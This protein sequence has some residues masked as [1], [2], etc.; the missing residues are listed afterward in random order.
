MYTPM[1]YWN[2]QG[3]TQAHAGPGWISFFTGSIN[4]TFNSLPFSASVNAGYPTF[5]IINFCQDVNTETQFYK[6]ITTDGQSSPLQWPVG[7]PFFCS[8][9]SP[10][11][12]ININT[13][14]DTGT[15]AWYID[16]SAD[17]G[18]YNSYSPTQY[19]S[20][21]NQ[22]GIIVNETLPFGE[23]KRIISQNACFF[24]KE[25]QTFPAG[26]YYG[27][28]L[29]WNIVSK[30]PGSVTPYV[31]Q[32]NPA[33]YEFTI[34]TSS[35]I[36]NPQGAFNVTYNAYGYASGSNYAFWQTGGNFGTVGTK[37]TFSGSVGL[38]LNIGNGFSNY[39]NT[40]ITNVT[41]TA[42]GALYL[43][44]CTT[45]HSLWVTLNN[46]VDV[47][48]TG[49]ILK[50]TNTELTTTS[51]CW[52]LSNFTSSLSVPVTV[53]N[54]IVSNTFNTCYTC[55]SGSLTASLNVDYLLVAGGGGGGAGEALGGPGGAGGGAGGLLSGS[56]T[57][58]PLSV[59]SVVIGTGGRGGSTNAQTGSNGLNSSIFGYTTI[60]G[61]YGGV[62]FK[63]GSN[64]GSGGGSGG[65]ASAL[66]GLGTSGQGN[67]GGSGSAENGGGAGGG[68]GASSVGTAW[69]YNTGSG[70]SSYA[71]S[72]GSGS[73]WLDGT[74]YAGG[75]AAGGASSY[76]VVPGTPGIGG[77]GTGGSEQFGTLATSGQAN[78]GAGGGGG[79]GTTP[80][81]AGSGSAGISIIRYPGTTQ[82]I[83]GGTV[84]IS[85]SYVYHTFT[86]SADIST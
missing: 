65:G 48:N 10:S 17:C 71:G 33:N 74:Y 34:M 5:P 16:V 56:Y 61:G 67:R 49:S 69:I 26:T 51:S 50:V 21:I 39:A 20:Y 14:P 60:G 3:A 58:Q 66:G 12:T 15:E 46:G 75:G 28:G 55:L 1:A 62:R 7:I 81:T 83:G 31:Y 25:D 42:K 23:T 59:Y 22:Y 47:Y 84:S 6:R 85:G 80:I 40:W 9:N 43:T 86:S 29:V 4:Y 30:F 72:G 63:S 38:P 73:Q 27:R 41:P 44:S 52:T 19:F 37:Y 13:P 11:G 76:G 35:I 54:V 32:K 53:E 77:G 82:L 78:R 18:V 24:I 36:N 2:T 64:G 70:Y 45:T 79:A 68:G 57:L 8:A